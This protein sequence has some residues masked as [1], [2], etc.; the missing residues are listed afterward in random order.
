MIFADLWE[1]LGMLQGEE[2]IVGLSGAGS[3]T[4]WGDQ[5]D[6]TF[7]DAPRVQIGNT[8]QVYKG[9]HSYSEN[10]MAAR[11]LL[12]HRKSSVPIED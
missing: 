10:R 3:E 8:H 7:S 4:A 12:R 6:R 5:K 1:M 9:V 2:E 11:G